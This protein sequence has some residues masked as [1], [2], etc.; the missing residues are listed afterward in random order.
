MQTKFMLDGI[1]VN[2]VKID[3]N[4][5]VDTLPPKVYTV[6]F[7]D[8]TGFYL[9]V[10]TEE[11]ELPE[12]IYGNTPQRVQKCIDTYTSRDSA[13]GILLTG[14]KGTGKSLLMSLLANQVIQQLD[15]PVLI[16]K[17]SFAGTQ[18]ETFIETIGECA[19]MFDEFGKMYASS[20]HQDGVQQSALL[21]LM[22][23]LDKT[24]RLFILSENSEMDI[25]EFMLNR[26]SRIYYHFK[27][28]KLD[29]SS[30]EGYCRDNGVA[31]DITQNVLELSRRSSIFSFDMLQSIVEEHLRFDCTVESAVEDLNIDLR[32]TRAEMMEVIKVVER[33]TNNEREVVDAFVT[34]PGRGARYTYIKGKDNSEARKNVPVPAGVDP[35][36]RQAM[37]EL[38]G[39]TEDESWDDVYVELA[40]LAYEDGL[41]LVYETEDY[42]FIARSVEPPAT[43]YLRLLA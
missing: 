32:E 12:K 29:E 22:D 27:Y 35:A 16:I 14:D 31:S 6:R 38:T 4:F 7:S 25:S 34:K 18:F 9:T 23:G 39:T 24:K 2:V 42:V 43:D 5:I 30:I 33:T 40:D 20:S 19:L 21:S 41:K 37:V 28:K 1:H 17:E 13:T 3:E 8:L 26:P 11:L 10:A 15:M 36:I